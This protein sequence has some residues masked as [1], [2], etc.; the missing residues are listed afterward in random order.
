MATHFDV[1][2][3]RM[4][5]TIRDY[6]LDNLYELD[7]TSFYDILESYMIKGLPKFKECLKPLDYILATKT[8]VSDFDM[9]EVDIIA[10]WGVI[11][12]Y[13]AELQ[14]VL[15]FKEPL[16]DS[17]FKR[18]ST[19]QNL[20]PRQDYLNALREKVKQD[21]VEYNLQHLSELPFF[22]EVIL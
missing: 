5:V 20:K 19:G 11:T 4:M 2:F 13:T 1:I 21:S 12:W 18:Y 22:N 16:G 7:P 17:D 14:D 15:E 3:D 6:K 10:E 9:Y 8:F